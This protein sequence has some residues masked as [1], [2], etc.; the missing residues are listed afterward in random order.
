MKVVFIDLFLLSKIV[1]CT[2]RVYECLL[3]LSYCDVIVSQ[4]NTEALIWG[5]G[6]GDSVR[7]YLGRKYTP[8][9]EKGIKKD[10]NKSMETTLI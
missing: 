5:G 3:L 10:Q 4:K 8:L 9:Y 2:K 6:V 1:F 7:I